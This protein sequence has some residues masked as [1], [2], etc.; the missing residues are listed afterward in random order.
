MHKANE[1][2]VIVNFFDAERLASKIVRHHPRVEM[3]DRKGRTAVFAAGEYSYGSK[4]A[5]AWSARVC[6]LKP[7]GE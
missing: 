7:E 6:S 4:V 5:C 2:D 1:P 3:Q